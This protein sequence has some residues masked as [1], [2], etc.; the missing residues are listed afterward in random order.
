MAHTFTHLLAHIV[1]STKDRMP[2][3]NP[4]LQVRLFPYMGGIVRELR[5]K[6]LI[7]NGTADHIHALVSMSPT[8]AV[9]DFM[10]VLK[11]NSSKWVNEEF[12]A[13]KHFAWQVGYGAFSVSHSSLA[14]V[15]KYIANQE[16]H[17]RKITFKEEFI[18][19]LKRHG[20]D[21]DERYIWE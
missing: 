3:L 9:S 1:F 19:L 14:Q 16:K 21:Y 6:A 17:H 13:W 4:A 7:I 2:L 20:M 8:V 18:A 5:S 12:S 10:R 15:T 11:T